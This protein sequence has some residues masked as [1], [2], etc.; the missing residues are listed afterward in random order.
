M[1]R[2]FTSLMAVICTAIILTTFTTTAY[3]DE[4][5]DSANGDYATEIEVNYHAYSTYT[6]ILPYALSEDAETEV[7]VDMSNVENGYHIN[8][9]VTNIEEDGQIPIYSENYDTN[10]AVGHITVIS[11]GQELPSDTGYFATFTHTDDI[12]N[13]AYDHIGYTI[14]DRPTVAG[15]YSGVI[16][17][18]FECVTD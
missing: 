8:A 7:A 3:A 18:N 4:Y 9:Y 13:Y 6:V 11:D 16:C 1:K 2:L 10:N 15:Q 14:T 5:V 17:F 12:N